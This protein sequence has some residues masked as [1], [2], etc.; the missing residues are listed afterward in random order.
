MSK[1]FAANFREGPSQRQGFP[2]LARSVTKI[3]LR[4]P[5][6]KLSAQVMVPNGA[7]HDQPPLFAL[8]GISRDVGALYDAFEHPA[9]HA[10][11]ILVVPH[12]HERDW[13]IFQRIGVARPDKSLL[14]LKKVLRDSGI[15][16]APQIELFGYSGGAQLAHRFAMLYP[17]H[18]SRLHLGAAGWYCLPDTSL[19][20][21]AGLREPARLPSDAPNF[22]TAKV[23]QLEQFLRIPLRIYVG[24]ED[25]ERDAAMRKAPDLDAV[26]G[27]NRLARA[28]TYVEHFVSAA[29]RLHG[30]ADVRL[31]LLPGCGHDFSQCAEKADLAHLVLS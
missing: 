31:T 6:G 5:E 1:M 30:T 3:V 24:T 2:G 4:T 22:R 21:P 9:M 14:A 13:K 29:A 15:C 8:H 7:E 16:S 26:Q 19:S 25:T 11:R 18:V 17:Q 28:A 12:F 27:V 23:A 10:G 20:Y